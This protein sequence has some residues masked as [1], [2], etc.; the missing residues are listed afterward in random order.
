MK[1]I[2]ILA[3][4]IMGCGFEAPH[5]NWK[6]TQ[7]LQVFYHVNGQDYFT[8]KAG[9]VCQRGKFSYGKTDRYVEVN[10]NGK[11]GWLIADEYLELIQG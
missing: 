5:G 11:Q 4:I 7:D 3:L 8:V 9:S 2:S 1:L 10:C 6:A